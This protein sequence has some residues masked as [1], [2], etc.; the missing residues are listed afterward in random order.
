MIQGQISSAE[1]WMVMARVHRPG[2]CTNSS[3]GQ[4]L[5]TPPSV[6]PQRK[7]LG[8]NSALSIKTPD[9]TPPIRRSRFLRQ[10]CMCTPVQILILMG[11]SLG[12][13]CQISYTSAWLSAVP[14][15]NRALAPL[16]GAASGS[17]TTRPTPG[18]GSVRPITATSLAHWRDPGL[19]LAAR[20]GK[21]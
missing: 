8:R 20:A 17:P 3:P 16:A 14:R 21:I 10:A 4:D 11:A 5:L 12:T 13:T 9:A 1:A 18:I 19:W 2:C 6:A 7:Y 15:S